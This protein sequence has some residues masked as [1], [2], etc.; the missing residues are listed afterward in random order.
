MCKQ[1]L[2]EVCQVII[3]LILNKSISPND[4]ILNQSMMAPFLVSKMSFNLYGRIS[5]NQNAN[6]NEI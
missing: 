6:H 4:T 3:I 5:F 2:K 1:I